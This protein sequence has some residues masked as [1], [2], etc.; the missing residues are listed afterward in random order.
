MNKEGEKASKAGSARSYA[1]KKKKLRKT[2]LFLNTPHLK[3]SCWEVGRDRKS[4]V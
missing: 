4:V 1:K 3:S 2:S